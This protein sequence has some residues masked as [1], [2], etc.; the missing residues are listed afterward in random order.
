MRAILA[1][2]LLAVIWPA[3][4]LADEDDDRKWREKRRE[5]IEKQYEK[6]R[7]EWWKRQEKAREHERKQWEDWTDR[8][9]WRGYYRPPGVDPYYGQR[10][11]YRPVPPY[12]HYDDRYGSYGRRHVYPPPQP[13]PYPR[14]RHDDDDDDIDAIYTPWGYYEDYP[15]VPY[16]ARR[17]RP[18]GRG[19]I[20]FEVWK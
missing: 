14:H 20:R 7:E 12:P 18:E 6:A 3:T 9:G 8:Q 17:P 4:A 10:Y 2:T 11:G 1:I 15:N 16:D 5:H 13:Y 19:Q